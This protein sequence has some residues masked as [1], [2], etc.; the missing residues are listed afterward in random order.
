MTIVYYVT[1]S[2]YRINRTNSMLMLFS[3]FAAVNAIYCC[4]LLS[5]PPISN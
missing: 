5:L 2:L 1:L 4:K 3:T